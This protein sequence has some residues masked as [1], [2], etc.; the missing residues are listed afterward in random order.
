MITGVVIANNVVY[1][2]S[3]F[4]WLSHHHQFSAV[5]KPRTAI[6]I[7]SC[8]VSEVK[9][10][11][12]SSRFLEC[13]P[14]SKPRTSGCSC[15]GGRDWWRFISLCASDVCLFVWAQNHPPLPGPATRARRAARDHRQG[16]QHAHSIIPS[17]SP[18]AGREKGQQI[19]G[20]R[21]AKSGHLFC[22]R[23]WKC[24]CFDGVAVGSVLTAH[25]QGKKIGWIFIPNISVNFNSGEM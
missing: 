14:L 13:A 22:R 7:V 20:D 1:F 10:R 21:R 16:R 6:R 11:A 8:A 17:T 23:R 3:S 5:W 2:K 9:A 18:S 4:R 24:T 19:R 25:F 15:A 12:E